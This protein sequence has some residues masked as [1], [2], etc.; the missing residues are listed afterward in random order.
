MKR[1]PIDDLAAELAALEARSLLRSPRTVPEGAVSLCS[2]DY[3]GLAQEPLMEDGT[4][5]HVAGGAGA[6]RLVS[7]NTHEHEALER[8]L[9][10]WLGV[11]ACLAFPSGYAANVG[12]LS[13][14]VRPGDRVLSDALNHASI[15]DGIR[16]AR[17]TVEIVPHLDHEAVARW[18][19][20]GPAGVR[21]WVVTESYFSMDADVPALAALSAVCAEAGAALYVDE[22]HSLGVFGPSGRGLC[23]AAGV[24]PDVLVGTFGKAFGLGGAFVAGRAILRKWLWNRARSF[25]FST[26]LSPLLAAEARRRLPR[27]AAADRERTHLLAL[28]DRLRRGLVA[29]GCDVR[30]V[31]P[32]VPWV[33]SDAAQAVALADALKARGYFVQAIRPPTVPEGTSRIRLSVT[34]AHHESDITGFLRAVAE[35]K[36]TWGA[37]S[38]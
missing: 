34:A 5:T 32:V 21:T 4:G 7:G 23:A 8:D 16:L 9:A 25:V 35:L 38:S 37:S 15:I 36:E 27:I 26:G 13:A 1:S 24:V 3:L 20:A 17:A 31:G 6:S 29:L 33:L 28:A 22:A 10:A 11:E 30:G 12:T 2:N 18:L 14:L 19:G